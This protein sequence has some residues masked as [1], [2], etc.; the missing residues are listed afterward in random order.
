MELLQV[1]TGYPD[2]LFSL[3]VSRGVV[4]VVFLYHTHT[5]EDSPQKG[6]MGVVWVE[7]V[8]TPIYTLVTTVQ[9]K[10]YTGQN[11]TQCTQI[12][13]PGVY[14]HRAQQGVFPSQEVLF[15]P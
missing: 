5:Y 6:M 2:K 15:P 11:F 7:F 8:S 14:L 10:I 12:P 13:L 9:P 4:S 3:C 1:Y